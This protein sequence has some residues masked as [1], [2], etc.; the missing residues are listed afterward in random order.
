M[1]EFASTFRGRRVF[2]TGHTG[3]KGAWL[4]LWL[5][6]L[7]A[8]VT[9]YSLGPPTT[10]NLFDLAH[11]RG[12]TARHHEADLRDRPAIR[13][14][15]IETEPD[16]V[17]HLAAQSAVRPG[18]QQP[19]E[20]FEINTMGT[21]S[22]LDAVRALGRPCAVVVVT[23]DKCY[24]NREHVWGYRETDAM[25]G[26]DPYSASKGAA[27]LVVSSYRRS[28]FD[29][30][31]VAEHGVK[32]ASARAGNVIGGGDFKADAIV[33]DLVRSRMA[34][35]PLEVRS[36]D[37]VRPWQHVLDCLS[38]YLSLSAQML[39]DDA[40]RWCD[41][42]N[43]GPLSGSEL[44]V[45][46]LVEKFADEWGDGDW[47]DTSDRRQPHEA[48]TLRLSIDKALWELGWRPRWGVEDAVRRTADWYRRW[49]VER[50]S[51]RELCEEQID[52]WTGADCGEPAGL[53]S[54]RS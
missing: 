11:V 42:W 31:R 8:E 34:G 16:L 53:V 50:A 52:A 30:A 9:G 24:E 28:F 7:G 18:Y 6:K 23:T 43:F 41:A 32:L 29:P 35:V 45:R 22:V 36:P 44:P 10:P 2:L 4:T 5:A 25:G 15:M 14:A 38:G 26:H 1:N 37:A 27:E 51:P 12:A 48:K 40:A 21:A 13:R 47:L 20:T 17:L 39:G 19:Y 33:P 49:H 46:D 3:F 54:V